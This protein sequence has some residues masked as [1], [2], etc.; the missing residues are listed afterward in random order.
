MSLLGQSLLKRIQNI[1]KVCKGRD[2]GCKLV[3]IGSG[4]IFATTGYGIALQKGSY[5]KR[6]VDLAILSI[7]GDGKLFGHALVRFA[8][9]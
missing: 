7:I 6:L 9:L 1:P 5:W 2:D 8:G 3:T 4:Y